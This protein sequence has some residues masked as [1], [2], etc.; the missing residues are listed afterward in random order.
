MSNPILLNIVQKTGYPIT[1][2]RV[3][4]QAPQIDGFLAI[5]SPEVLHATQYI[6]LDNIAS[7][8]VLDR[9]S[10]NIIDSF[11]VRTIKTIAER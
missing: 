10:I 3:Q 9:E 6:S 2:A 1:G 11:P 8:T 4:W 7:F 5:E